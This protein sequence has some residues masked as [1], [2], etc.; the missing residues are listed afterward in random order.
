MELA[1]PALAEG[2][3]FEVH[4]ARW[5]VFESYSATGLHF[6]PRGAVK[7]RAVV[8]PES[9]DAALRL[10]ARGCEVIAV[11][12]IDREK[13]YAVSEVLNRPT[14]LSHRE[15]VYRMAFPLGRHPVGYDTQAVLAA[16]RW[17]AAQQPSLPLWAAGAGDGAL[18]VLYA[19]A[20]G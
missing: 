5:A 4:A 16:A 9:N 10:A 17:L 3:G 1:L 20:L 8:A 11:S 15:L 19:A 2:S 12:I 18:A 14:G 13:T 6:K 7:C